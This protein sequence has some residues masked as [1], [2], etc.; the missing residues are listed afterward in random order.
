MPAQNASFTAL[1]RSTPLRPLLA[2]ALLAAAALAAHPQGSD[3]RFVALA[4]LVLA[5]C[6]GAVALSPWRED[7]TWLPLVPALSALVAI[8]LLRQSQGGATS[9][10]SPLAILAVVWVAGV[11]DRRAVRLVTACSA[12]DLRRA[13]AR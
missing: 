12:T 6:A 2:F 7:S 3:W 11:L 10:Y 5:V 9:G 4:A 13:A 8:A 1:H